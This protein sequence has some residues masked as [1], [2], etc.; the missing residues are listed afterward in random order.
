ML[1]M[2]FLESSSQSVEFPKVNVTIVCS[3]NNYIIVRETLCANIN[4]GPKKACG[5]QGV[6]CV[7][8]EFLLV[9]DQGA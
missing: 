8:T 6:R 3:Y 4:L 2:L 1:V 5:K 9:T 7:N